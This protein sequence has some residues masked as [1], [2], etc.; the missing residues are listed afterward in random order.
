MKHELLVPVG[1]YLSLI[2]AI[3]NGADAVY[4]AGKKY[5]ARAFA[6]NFSLDELADVIKLCH[7]HGVKVFIT[8]NTLVFECEFNEALDYIESI[9]KMG[10]DAVIMQDIG[11]ISVVH[12]MFPNL[13]IHASTQ[14]HNHSSDSIKFLESLGVKRVVFA[15]ELSLDYI[16]NV[17]TKMDKEIFI[18]GSLCVSYSG[19]C[20][21]S[22]CVLDRSANR[23]ECAGMCRLKYDLFE[24]NKLVNTNGNYLLSPMDLCSINEIKKLLESNV[25]SFKI[26][27]RMKSPLYVATI[28]RIYRSLIDKY[29]RG[30]ELLVSEEDMNLLK[31]VFYRGYTKG[32][33][34]NESNI[35]NYNSSNHIG[36]K[37]AN[38]LEVNP[39]KIK[40]KALYDL[41]Q[42]DGIR[43]KNSDLGA[44]L[45]FI[46]DKNDNLINSVKKGEIFYI[47]NFVKLKDLDSIYLTNPYIKDNE[48]VT[49]KNKINISFVAK[50]GNPILLC[51]SDG[52]FNIS[53]EG[54]VPETAV[55]APS[56]IE[57]IKKSLVKTGD[58]VFVVDDI[59]IV[60]DDNL[61]VRSGELNNLRRE[62]LDELKSLRKNRNL[63]FVKNEIL[64]EQNSYE[65]NSGIF[66]VAKTKE[67]IDVLKKYN[68]NIIVDNSKLLEKNYL[69]KIPRNNLKY[70]YDYNNYLITSYASMYKFRNNISDYFLNITNHYALE[71]ALKYNKIVTLS[72]EN[73]FK[74]VSDIMK[75]NKNYPVAAFIYGRIE[76]MMMKSCILKNTLGHHNCSICTSNHKYSLRDRNGA[77]YPI[78]T[79]VVN[80]TSYILDNRKTDLI[81]RIPDY[82]ALGVKN[83]RIDLFDESDYEVVNL[84]EKL[85]NYNLL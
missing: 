9:H 75:N 44:T 15:R 68:V 84:M 21:F 73:T 53:L 17:Q 37:V 59:S 22:K 63:N 6:D 32:L 60:I 62:L 55:N 50:K 51:V 72:P 8:V 38:V 74:D 14:M 80:H 71:L 39:K 45:N 40:I 33:L 19:Q 79:D 30:E 12:N 76:L 7:L 20:Y 54:S 16:N 41:K 35:M 64:L 2:A 36:L 78:T 52:E 69:Y 31:S 42:G 57:N 85:K 23:G 28:T 58:T 43:F 82:L 61:F 25:L 13:E 26:E 27:G 77:F 81:N 5:G 46:Y 1:N 66:V 18:Q 83:F 11:L 4:L 65:N 67:Q 48:T 24:D 10:V 49:K 34:F 47:D 3:N 56:T 70:D 29:E